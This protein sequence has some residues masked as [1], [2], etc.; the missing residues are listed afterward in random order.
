MSAWG[1]I[2]VAAEKRERDEI[3]VGNLDKWGN[4]IKNL[5]LGKKVGGSSENI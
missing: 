3:S 5:I 1:G 4:E 2:S